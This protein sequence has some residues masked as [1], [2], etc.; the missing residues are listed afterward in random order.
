GGMSALADRQAKWAVHPLGLWEDAA[1]DTRGIAWA[2]NLNADMK[3]Y[4]TG[5]V[6]LNFIGDEGAERVV[7]G[8]GRDNYRRLAAIKA[9]WDPENV[10]RQNH[11]IAPDAPG[12]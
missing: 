4:A 11:N 9:E 6:Y 12:D 10:F 7:A 2:R 3:S 1:D 8:F 5:A